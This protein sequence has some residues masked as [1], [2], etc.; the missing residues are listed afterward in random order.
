M[1]ETVFGTHAYEQLTI[2]VIGAGPAGLLAAYRLKKASLNVRLIEARSRIGGRV[3]SAPTIRAEFGAWSLSNAGKPELF[4]TLAQ[5][6][7]LTLDDALAPFKRLWIVNNQF[8]DINPRFIPNSSDSD[9]HKLRKL[10]ETIITLS[11]TAQDALDT[12]YQDDTFVKSFNEKLLWAFFGSP[13]KELSA[14]L[15][16]ESIIQMCLGGVSDVYKPGPR[17]APLTRVVGGNDQFVKKMAKYLEGNIE[18]NMPLTAINRGSSDKLSLTFEDGTTRET[19]LL[20]LALPVFAYKEL[21]IEEGLI[22]SS[23]LASIRQVCPGNVTKVLI[24]ALGAQRPPGYICGQDYGA[25]MSEHERFLTLYWRTPF[26]L[27]ACKQ[28]V[29]IIAQTLGWTVPTEFIKVN[30]EQAIEDY[31]QDAVCVVD[32]VNT[33][34]TNGSYCAYSPANEEHMGLEKI[35]GIMV[36]SLFKPAGPLYFVGEGAGVSTPAGTLGAAFESADIVAAIIKLRLLG[37]YSNA[38]QKST[39]ARQLS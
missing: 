33:P 34:Y 2:T 5:E 25:A 24:P 17:Y 18:L 7:G 31:P 37:F 14:K 1:I 4:T 28:Q 3:L 19:D 36:N 16:K 38:L 23:Q 8:V 32:W 20:V 13:A 39:L 30:D 22:P 27:D 9:P 6:L 11:P 26:D 15:Y 29:E 35:E 12:F 10:L 21:A